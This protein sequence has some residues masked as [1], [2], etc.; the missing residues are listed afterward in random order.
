[1]VVVVVVVVDPGM[2]RFGRG[3]GGG[4]WGMEAKTLVFFVVAMVGA[5]RLRCV[6]VCVCVGN[7]WGWLIGW[8]RRGMFVEQGDLCP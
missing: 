5:W 1:M 7:V 6:Y 8:R 3:G 2:E 4:G